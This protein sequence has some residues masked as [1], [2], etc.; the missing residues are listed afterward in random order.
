MRMLTCKRCGRKWQKRT[1][2]PIVCPKC[3]SAKW[4]KA[5]P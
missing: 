2:A 1:D 4:R 3:K 5:K